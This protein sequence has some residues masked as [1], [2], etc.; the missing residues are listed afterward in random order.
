MLMMAKHKVGVFTSPYINDYSEMI[1]VNGIHISHEKI[2]SILNELILIC[3]QLTEFEII[4]VIAFVFFK[5]QNVDYAVIE[6]GM[7]GLEDA[8]NVLSPC[9][10]IITNISDDHE[11][12][13]QDIV[14]HKLGIIKYNIPLVTGVQ[15]TDILSKLYKLTPMSTVFQ[16]K[17]NFST[18]LKKTQDKYQVIE[19]IDDS[20]K[21]EFPLSLMGNY[22]IMNCGLAIKAGLL[23]GISIN[24]ITSALSQ[25]N[26]PYRFEIIK[27]YNKMWILDSAHN[28]DG[29][30]QLRKSLDNY[31]FDNI[32]FIIAILKDKKYKEMLEILINP[33]DRAFF[34]TAHNERACDPQILCSSAPTCREK[35][36]SENYE[37]AIHSVKSSNNSVICITGTLYNED[38]PRRILLSNVD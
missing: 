37:S 10:E 33:N 34:V 17:L 20:H 22:Q 38:I 31:N 27:S 16:Y 3:D 19:Y 30:Q 29:I 11:A 1:Q 23:L 24:D 32:T 15:D 13:L 12:I 28:L 8:T 14:K 7:G 35:H 36:V 26:I 5:N 4:T 18:K 21:F 25:V 2:C 9:L 6:V